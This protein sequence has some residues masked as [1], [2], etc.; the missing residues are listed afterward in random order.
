[1]LLF[2][3]QSRSKTGAPGTGTPGKQLKERNELEPL[4]CSRSLLYL[5]SG[6]GTL[7]GLHQGGVAHLRLR[8][9]MGWRGRGASERHSGWPSL[10]HVLYAAWQLD[11][12]MEISPI[13][14]TVYIWK[15][16]SAFCKREE[17]GIV[18]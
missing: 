9:S 17:R 4:S 1:M 12:T 10:L 11:F 14:G 16:H 2:I 7:R 8:N 18:R 15:E 13:Q 3:A 5:A 6:A